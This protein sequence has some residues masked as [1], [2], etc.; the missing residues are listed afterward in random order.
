MLFCF[1][2]SSHVFRSWLF[3]SIGCGTHSMKYSSS[4]DDHSSRTYSAIAFHKF[5]YLVL[6]SIGTRPMVWCKKF[7]PSHALKIWFFERLL[8]KSKCTN[9][10]SRQSSK[11]KSTCNRVAGMEMNRVFFEFRHEEIRKYQYGNSKL[12]LKFKHHTAVHM[13]YNTTGPLKR[14]I[15]KI[16]ALSLS[17]QNAKR[18]SEIRPY[19]HLIIS[20]RE[21]DVFTLV[22]LPFSSSNAVTIRKQNRKKRTITGKEG[23]KMGGKSSKTR[24]A[25][26]AQTEQSQQENNQ[27]RTATAS[28]SRRRQRRKKK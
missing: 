12:R 26:A 20:P 3:L 16:P 2:L 22:R 7:H 25:P 6:P 11:K 15:K 14:N 23:E 21:I 28:T 24:N 10:Q 17:R 5:L 8:T 13:Q 1:F 27:S 18:T 4:S 9:F 19:T